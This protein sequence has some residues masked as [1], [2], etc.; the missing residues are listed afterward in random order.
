VFT[1]GVLDC[2]IRGPTAI[3]NFSLPLCTSVMNF[4]RLSADVPLRIR[5]NLP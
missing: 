1:H 4:A 2:S 3:A 5:L